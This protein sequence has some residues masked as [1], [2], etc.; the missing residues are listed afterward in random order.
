MKSSRSKRNKKDRSKRGSSRSKSK[1]TVSARKLDEKKEGSKRGSSR[2]KNQISSRRVEGSNRDGSRR[3]S[4]RSEKKLEKK[5]SSRSNKEK[6]GSVKSQKYSPLNKKKSNKSN[7][8]EKSKKGS[9]KS[10]KKAESVKE[11]KSDEAKTPPYAAPSND[12][13]SVYLDTGKSSYST[14]NPSSVNPNSIYVNDPK[15]VKSVR[16]DLADSVTPE[17]KKKTMR[18]TVSPD[19]ESKKR[20]NKAVTPNKSPKSTIVLER[21]LQ[22]M[23]PRKLWSLGSPKESE[24]FPLPSKISA[25]FKPYKISVAS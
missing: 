3:G 24:K 17:D 6:N 19:G 16:S 4:V 23:C 11:I 13:R 5:Q 21:K 8:K 18:S 25:F 20:S 22:R 1:K 2:S 10:V 7:K 12:V 14:P 9:Q 15:P